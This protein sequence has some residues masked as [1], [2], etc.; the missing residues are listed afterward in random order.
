[1][2]VGA[3]PGK[4]R[5]LSQCTQQQRRL[6]PAPP[7]AGARPGFPPPAPSRPRPPPPDVVPS[8]SS[9]AAIAGVLQ[10][11]LGPDCVANATVLLDFYHIEQS[12]GSVV[13]ILAG[14][15]GGMTVLTYAAL[16]RGAMRQVGGK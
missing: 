8:N 11:G 12:W 5:G 16:H 15:L 14:Y 10:R 1:V 13:G 7:D 9:I 6:G 4:P 3:G 2:G